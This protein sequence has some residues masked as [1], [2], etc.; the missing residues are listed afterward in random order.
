M[1][2][3]GNPAVYFEIPVLDLER[4]IAFYHAVFDY[5]F[6]RQ[7][8]DG[9][10]MALFPL[11]TGVAGITGALAKGDVYK[12]SK[13]GSII[14]LAT[15]AIEHTLTLVEANGGQVLYPKTASGDWGFIAE[16]EDTEGNRVALHEAAP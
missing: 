1:K 9:Y 14:Y 4:A 12:P 3:P 13:E 16:F 15:A 2:V 10:E 11:V 8:V 5:T 7:E 6:E